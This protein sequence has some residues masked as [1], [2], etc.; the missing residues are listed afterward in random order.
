MK[1]KAIVVIG[2]LN[3]DLIFQQERLPERG[4]TYL[5]DRAQ[6]SSGGK[7][8][9]QAVQAAKLGAK[10]YMV[11]ALGADFFGQYL[12]QTIEG[13]GVDVSHLKKSERMTGIAAVH[14]L[15]DGV[16]YSTVAPGS[17]M[18]ISKEDIDACKDLIEQVAV[19]V[20]QLEI[21]VPVVEYVIE[22]AHRAGTYVI[23]NAA[24]AAPLSESA[25]KQLDC[26]I[27]NEVEASYYLGKTIA[28]FSDVQEN[29]AVIMEKLDGGSCIITLGDRGSVLCNA[30]GTSTYTPTPGI[31]AIETTGS[32]DSYVGAF[33]YMRSEG[34]SE[35]EAC[36][37]ASRVAEYTV[38]QVG[39]QNAMPDRKTIEAYIAE[40]QGRIFL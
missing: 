19:V 29:Y 33:A 1:E 30:K 11:G 25:M 22:L 26:F 40:K 39:A 32:G 13:Y 8:A 20:L 7:G 35:E 17:N 4:E 37:F 38:T 24:P 9:N 5:G 2:S 28:S 36:A 6:I 23:L 15:P 31:K 34:H 10:T 14:T 3:C 21:P 27:V 18:D 12:K 16:Y